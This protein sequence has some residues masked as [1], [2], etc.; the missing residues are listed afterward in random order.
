[1]ALRHFIFLDATQESQAPFFAER[2]IFQT[3]LRSYNNVPEALQSIS[4]I[5]LPYSIQVYMARDNILDDGLPSD[6]NGPMRTLIETFCGLRTIQHVSIFCPTVNTDLEQQIRSI[7]PDP[8]LIKNVIS[9]IDLH[10]YMCTEGI[11]YFREEI[12]RCRCTKDVHLIPNFQR[13]IDELM[14]YLQRVTNDQRPILDALVEER[15]NQPGE[16]PL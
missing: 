7:I 9:A 13:N 11:T 16:Q 5:T 8:R 15:S 4:K 3:W 10:C 1:M 6:A 14:E 2:P 12:R